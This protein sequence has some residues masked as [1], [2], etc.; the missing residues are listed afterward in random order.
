MEIRHI[1][2]GAGRT[3][4]TVDAHN[5]GGDL[6]IFIRNECPHVGAVAV[7]EYDAGSHRTSVSV[8]T[9][10]GH[11]DDTVAQRAAHRISKSLK[12]P[13]CVVA[14][15]HVDDITAEEI[16]SILRNADL[17]VEELLQSMKAC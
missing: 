5:L 4:V 10:P 16:E 17:A 8:I 2:R 3:R 7:G 13:V 12:S 15:I 11:K 14:G 6:V 1:D 9:R